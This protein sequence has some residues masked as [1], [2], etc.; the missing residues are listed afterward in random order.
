[1]PT[2]FV[3]TLRNIMSG[4][5][6]IAAAIA[7]AIA[8]HFIFGTQK[9]DLGWNNHVGVLIIPI[10]ACL[11]FVTSIGREFQHNKKFQHEIFKKSSWLILAALL[12]FLAYMLLGSAIVE[13]YR[14]GPQAVTYYQLWPTLL[15]FFVNYGFPIIWSLALL[16]VSSVDKS[17]VK[18]ED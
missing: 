16:Y 10:G 13:N 1:M 2:S 12:F 14:K 4:F 15:L 11:G 3:I 17:K 9:I 18:H 6:G 7:A 5:I 8:L